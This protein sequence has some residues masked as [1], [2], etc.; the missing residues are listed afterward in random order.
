MGA[1]MSDPF[2]EGDI[3]KTIGHPLMVALGAAL[4][5]LTAGRSPAIGSALAALLSIAGGIAFLAFSLMLPSLSW[6]PWRTLLLAAFARKANFC[7][8]L[9]PQ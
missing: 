4:A 8:F 6:S 5:W 9:Y 7:C 3:A 2:S 1:K